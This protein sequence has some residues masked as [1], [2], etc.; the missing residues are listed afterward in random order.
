MIQVLGDEYAKI[1]PLEDACIEVTSTSGENLRSSDLTNGKSVVD[2][3][4]L[5]DLFTIDFHPTFRVE[6]DMSGN[7]RIYM[8]KMI[9][10]S[11]SA[12]SAHNFQMLLE[13]RA[14]NSELIATA[15]QERIRARALLRVHLAI[16]RQNGIKSIDPSN[17]N[18][19]AIDPLSRK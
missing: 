15:L 13:S 11:D 4:N 10:V 3:T 6:E 17:D 2:I 8:S 9:G 7:Q 12:N 1:P 18:T 16:T 14:R 5:S 19:N